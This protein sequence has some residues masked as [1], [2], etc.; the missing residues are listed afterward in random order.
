MSD[1]YV[2]F[3]DV[4]V[5]AETDKAILCVI[6]EDEHWVP[7]SQLSE[8]SEVYA[9]GTEGKLVVSEWLAKTKGLV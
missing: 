7:K 3:E 8:D 4:T 6:G 2:E 1:E 9:K 5:K